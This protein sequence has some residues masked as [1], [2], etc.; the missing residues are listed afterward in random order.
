MKKAKNIFFIRDGGRRERETYPRG[1]P[2]PPP[3]SGHFF[4]FFAV[5]SCM[6]S[7]EKA[8]ATKIFP[9]QPCRLPPEYD[10]PGKIVLLFAFSI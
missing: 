4:Y 8:Y 3:L 7:S 6:K 2:G 9:K 10:E 5:R 1:I